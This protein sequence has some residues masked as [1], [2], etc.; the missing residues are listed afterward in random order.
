MGHYVKDKSDHQEVLRNL[1]QRGVI[2]HTMS[3]LD[4]QSLVEAHDALDH[5][6]FAEAVIGALPV[7][8]WK[9]VEIY[10]RQRFVWKPSARYIRK[11][12]REG[13][14]ELREARV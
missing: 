11:L 6:E 2:N 8:T 3:T 5:D 12:E 14:K 7:P 1:V 9:V 13:Q 10:K 4:M